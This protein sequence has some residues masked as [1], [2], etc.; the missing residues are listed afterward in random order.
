MF[1]SGIT[2]IILFNYLKVF[3][4]HIIAKLLLN[5]YNSTITASMQM[6]LS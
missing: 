1:Y 5:L 6:L 4:M 3:L 2:A